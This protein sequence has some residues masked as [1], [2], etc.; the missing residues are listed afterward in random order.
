MLA[1]VLSRHNFREADQII[2]LYTLEQ[3]KREALARGVKKITSKN[4]GSLE[5]FSVV[6]VEIIPGKEIDHIGS[7]QSIELFKN[8]RSDFEKMTIAQQAVSIIE[9]LFSNNEPDAPSFNVIFSWL[10]N[11]N[12]SSNASP[13]LLDAFM[14]KLL[15]RLGFAP[16]LEICVRCGN[17]PS[18]LRRG[19]EGE[20]SFTFDIAA[21][22]LICPECKQKSVASEQLFPLTPVTL[23]TL[24]TFITADWKP[25]FSLILGK[26]EAGELHKL[27][28][29]FAVFHSGKKLKEWNLDRYI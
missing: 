3:G 29:K 16:G 20:V 1:I 17:T 18:P 26:K 27:V 19:T 6:E 21:G 22:G 25:I 11:L 4:S 9:Q 5:S 23:Q 2:S 10:Q 24:R 12:Q 7:V 15:S 14:I 13:I 8:I 28:Y